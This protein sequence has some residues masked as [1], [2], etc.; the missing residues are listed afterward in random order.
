MGRIGS[1]QGGLSMVVQYAST[2]ACGQSWLLGVGQHDLVFTC[3]ASWFFEVLACVAR[4]L[5][6]CHFRVFGMLPSYYGFYSG[7]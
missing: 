1:S 2:V 5:G 3:V 6:R 7:S 4:V